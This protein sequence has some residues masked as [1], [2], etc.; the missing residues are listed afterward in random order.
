[1][2]QDQETTN[3]IFLTAKYPGG[4]PVD[5]AKKM[6]IS[7][8]EIVKEDENSS[9]MEKVVFDKWFSVGNLLDWI[10]RGLKIYFVTL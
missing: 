2:T 8:K 3:P 10:N 5:I 7:T 9:P 6:L 4:S 1:M